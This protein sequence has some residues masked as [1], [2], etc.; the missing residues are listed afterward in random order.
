MVSNERPK[1]D[2][3]FRLNS[4]YTGGPTCECDEDLAASCL[5]AACGLSLE[6]A[7]GALCTLLSSAC[8]TLLPEQVCANV[9]ERVVCPGVGGAPYLQS[10]FPVQ[11]NVGKH[12]AVVSASVAS[13]ANLMSTKRATRAYS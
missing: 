13:S 8:P 10:L 7:L 1:D 3:G 6:P 11:L 12:A 5:R 4:Q 9:A 2:L